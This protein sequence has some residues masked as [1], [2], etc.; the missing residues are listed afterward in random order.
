M[1]RI[2]RKRF[3]NITTYGRAKKYDRCTAKSERQFRNFEGCTI[4]PDG[5]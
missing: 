4:T 5:M 1:Y 2:N 3:E